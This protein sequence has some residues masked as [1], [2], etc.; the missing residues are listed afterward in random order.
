MKKDNISI[1]KLFAVTTKLA[2]HTAT[3]NCPG[4]GNTAVD[5]NPGYF[6]INK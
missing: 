1:E 3:L 6:K 4:T 2:Q 5:S